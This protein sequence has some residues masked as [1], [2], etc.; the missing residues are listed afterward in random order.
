M[1]VEE[2]KQPV[3]EEPP[4]RRKSSSAV[5]SFYQQLSIRIDTPV[6]NMSISPSGR[7]IVLASRVGLY[8]LDLET[9]YK[10]PRVIH[11]YS[12]W[13]VADVMWNPHNS[14][15]TWIVSTANQKTLVW[16]VASSAPRSIEYVLH[17]HSRAITDVS[18][19]PIDPQLLGTSSIDT[20]V[21]IWDLRTPSKP[22]QSFCAWTAGAT[23]IDFN[24]NNEYM[25]AS[26]HETELN[27]W[28]CRA[29][30]E[31]VIKFSPQNNRIFG[32]NWNTH[33]PKEIL[34]CGL[35]KTVKIWNIDDPSVCRG[36]ITTNSPIRR[37]RFTP[38]GDGIITMPQR[39]DP[40]LYMWSRSDLSKP[41]CKFEGHTDTIREFVWR[42]R[43]DT[44]GD[45]ETFQD[46]R[47]F[48]L[49]SWSNDQH[50]RLWPIDDPNFVVSKRC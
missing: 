14:R 40:S 11:H 45:K 20:F 49:V 3:L 29:R 33:N 5:S 12:R 9:P 13:D 43:G 36:T 17:G 7:D 16:N 35:D 28:D 31:P 25:I 38:F 32:I 26:S 23:Q 41:V 2:L 24:P 10:P 4:F 39:G 50:L 34:T 18:W 37:A 22:S 48:Q 6:R 15:D 19:S 27:I 21:H 8:I 44:M 46:F 30:T 1:T 47:E 42:I